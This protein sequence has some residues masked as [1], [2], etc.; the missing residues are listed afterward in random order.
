MGADTDF[1]ED[2]VQTH[3]AFLHSIILGSGKRLVMSELREIA[4][5]AGFLCPRTLVAT[6]NLVV[7]A[8]HQT[9]AAAIEAALENG[10]A[11][12]FGKRIDVIVRSAKDFRHLHAGNPFPDESR[13]DASRVCVS[14][15]RSPLAGVAIE[16]LKDWSG[17]ADK[18]TLL[19]GDLWISFGGKP[20]ESRLLSRLTTR[21][22][23]IG[24]SRNWNT[25]D[26][27][28]K[29]IPDSELSLRA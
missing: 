18:F 28:L 7:E 17:P 25:I 10:I 13:A 15:Q 22:L 5:D 9:P 26:G 3:V 14:I 1:G 24:T 11:I 12:R 21:H 27:L 2:S 20:S 4:V 29:L 23:G 8:H 19:R 6:G 16:T